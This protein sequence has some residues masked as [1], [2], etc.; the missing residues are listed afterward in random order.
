M[1]G[2]SVVAD[3]TQVWFRG[4][5]RFLETRARL[6][7]K[8]STVWPCMS[9]VPCFASQSTAASRDEAVRDVTFDVIIVFVVAR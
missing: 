9:T 1:K 2:S 4:Y 6:S 3:F 5:F 7:N 8:R